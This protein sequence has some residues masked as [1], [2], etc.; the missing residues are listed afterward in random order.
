V[1]WRRDGADRAMSFWRTMLTQRD[2]VTFDV[3]RVSTAAAM[4]VHCGLTVATFVIHRIYDPLSF[5]TGAAG[6]V[7]AGN[8][9]VRMREGMDSSP[10]PQQGPSQQ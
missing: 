10:P 1:A 6:I 2:N 7:G 3:A 4:A 8:A 9:A 5:M